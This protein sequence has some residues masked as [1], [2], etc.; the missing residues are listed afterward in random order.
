MP[1]SISANSLKYNSKPPTHNATFHWGLETTV[2]SSEM[3]MKMKKTQRWQWKPMCFMIGFTQQ[4][5]NSGSFMFGLCQLF[6]ENNMQSSFQFSTSRNIKWFYLRTAI[7]L[8]DIIEQVNIWFIWNSPKE[9][10]MP[11]TSSK[12]HQSCVIVVTLGHH[13]KTLLNKV[14]SSKTIQQKFKISK[15]RRHKSSWFRENICKLFVT[16]EWAW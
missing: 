5:K 1:Q 15:T 3:K 14:A 6:C 16:T 8:F 11:Q 7:F 12:Y 4:I 9:R 13:Y 2:I 10:K